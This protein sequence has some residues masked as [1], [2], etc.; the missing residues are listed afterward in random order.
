LPVKF[1]RDANLPHLGETSSP[2]WDQIF[3]AL[4]PEI[5]HSR[6]IE[7]YL[8]VYSFENFWFESGSKLE[9]MFRIC[10]SILEKRQGNEEICST[11][12]LA[13]LSNF[14]PRIHLEH[15]HKNSR[16][17]KKLCSQHHNVLKT[18]KFAP[19]V[20]PSNIALWCAHPNNHSG[21]TDRSRLL[22]WH[23]KTHRVVE[24]GRHHW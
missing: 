23:C 6:D 5:W 15:P 13:F 4:I 22:R 12:K 1:G 14:I 18:N 24:D 17:Q 10:E 19:S 11:C 7:L 2:S 8:Y 16:L 3:C 20:S 9:W 21:Q